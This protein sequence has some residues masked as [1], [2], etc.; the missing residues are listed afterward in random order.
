MP[1]APDIAIAVL[2]LASPILL[3]VLTWVA[4]KA[5][6]LIHGRVKNE[7]LRGVLV[8]LDDTV[9]TVVREI[10]QVTVD[11]LK[12]AAPN[13]KLGSDVKA[14]LKRSAITAI[15]EHLGPRGLAELARVLGLD[16]EAVDRMIGTRV[17]AT[18]HDLKQARGVTATTKGGGP[19]PLAA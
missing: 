5:A 9:L 16:E 1:H 10:H 19:Y 18:V 3:A 4:T 13:G 14:M 15:K 12:A 11:T 7:Y 8:R 2:Q 17:E 6:Q